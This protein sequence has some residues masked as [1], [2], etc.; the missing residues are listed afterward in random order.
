M[1]NKLLQIIALENNMKTPKNFGGTCGVLNVGMT[2]IVAM[3]IIVGF[4]GYIKYGAE[5]SG[6]ITLNLPTDAV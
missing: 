3:Y 1:A 5:A 4:F 6:S 2:M